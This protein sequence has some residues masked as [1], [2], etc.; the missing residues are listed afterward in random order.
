[1]VM[2]L[3]RL[4]RWFRGRSGIH[5][6]AEFS[7]LVKLERCRADRHNTVFSLVLFEVTRNLRKPEQVDDMIAAARTR[8]RCTDAIGWFDKRR[9][10]VLLHQTHIAGARL[11]ADDILLEVADGAAAIPYSVYVYPSD[12]PTRRGEMARSEALVT[13]S[14][15]G[16]AFPSSC[17][18]SRADAVAVMSR[19]LPRW[20]RSV[21]I[22][23]AIAVLFALSPL[24][25]IIALV[26]KF[27]SKGQVF[28]SQQRVGLGGELFNMYK[29]RSMVMDAEAL[30]PELMGCNERLGPAFKMKNDPRVIKVGRFLRRWSLDEL[31]QLF[32]VLR[33]DMSLVGPRPPI[34]EE[35]AHYEQWQIQRLDMPPG[36][37]CIWQTKSRHIKEFD[38]WVREDIRYL[39]GQSF[40]LDLRLLLATIPAVIS[41]KGAC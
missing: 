5:S 25:L 22:V 39:H 19:Q 17:Q 13:G 31:P 27:A 4:L 21:D 3:L 38:H 2:T 7:M 18:A 41:G 37:T 12:H 24:F 40:W 15:P 32:N 14:V 10:A 28:F 26:I 23:G 35:V 33:G 29:F 11:V 20:K 36:I 6:P 9:I 1:M 30:K 34:P 16:R 8:L